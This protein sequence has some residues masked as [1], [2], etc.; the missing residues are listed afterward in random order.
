MKTNPR[1]KSFLSSKS[2]FVAA[3]VIFISGGIAAAEERPILEI[4]TTENYIYSYEEALQVAIDR[5]NEY[6]ASPESLQSQFVSYALQ[7]DGTPYWYGG[8]SP[9]AFDCSGLV[10]Y[11]VKHV[12]GYDLRHS[13]SAQMASG[14]RVTTPQP[15]DLVGWG[16]GRYF[17]HIGIY[18]GDGQVLNALNPRRDTG[19]WSL[20]QM[21]TWL[22]KPTFVRIIPDDFNA[23]AE[24]KDIIKQQLNAYHLP[25]AS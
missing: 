10:S 13:A 2:A 17:K 16:W 15:G 18:I 4:S 22:G 11:T 25:V 19:I 12:L 20:D 8:A 9:T 7:F 24:A 5:H 14:P 3:V 1:V 6:L 21:N 23:D